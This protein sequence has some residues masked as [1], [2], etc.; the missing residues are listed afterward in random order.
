MLTALKPPRKTSNIYLQNTPNDGK[1]NL[2][3]HIEQACTRRLGRI[4]SYEKRLSYEGWIFGCVLE[5]QDDQTMR[6]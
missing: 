1:I 4:A 3:V 6:S 5:R 2:N